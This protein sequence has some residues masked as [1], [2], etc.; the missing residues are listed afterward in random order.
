MMRQDREAKLLDIAREL[1]LEDGMVSFKFTDIA[2][3][4]EISRATLYKYFSGKEDVLVSLFV[5]DA[6]NTRQM[7]VDILNY[8]QLN[9]REKLL[10]A[11]LAPVSI[12]SST[13]NT[14]GIAF[15]SANPGIY[16]F[17]G[18]K[19]QQ[20]LEQILEQLRVIHTQFWMMPV[21]N[22]S[23]IAEKEQITQVM[24]AVYPYQRGC[25][26]IPQSIMNIGGQIRRPLYDV[27]ENLIKYTD[28]LQWQSGH[29]DTDYEKILKAIGKFERNCMIAS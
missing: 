17:A 24:A 21:K 20:Q 11:M 2:K 13:K 6:G 28:N 29:I 16:S 27:Y 10:T 5:H 15:L 4:A 1:I 19:Q 8:E 18:E 22:G 7:L 14:L 23:L 25:V 9:D 26:L 3:R 12:S